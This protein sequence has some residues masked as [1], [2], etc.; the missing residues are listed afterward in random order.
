MRYF[1]MAR[2]VYFME[3]AITFCCGTLERWPFIGNC[4]EIGFFSENQYPHSISVDTDIN[5]Y[6]NPNHKKL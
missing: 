6:N 5:V 2:V 1:V 4:R 3:I